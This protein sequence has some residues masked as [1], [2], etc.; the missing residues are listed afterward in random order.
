ME[1]IFQEENF[2]IKTLRTQEEMEAAFRLR[3]EVFCDEL[4]WVPSFPD[5]MERDDYDAFADP[6]GLFD[7]K[8][9]LIGH[10]RLIIAPKPFMIEKEFA[11]L[12][13]KDKPFRKHSNL[14]ESTRICIK[15]DCRKIT[16]GSFTVAHLLY[17]AIYQWCLL[18]DIRFFVTIIEKRYYRYLKMFF[19]F[20][21]LGKFLPLGDG[22]LSGIVLMDCRK[23][24]LEAQE[25]RP[26]FFRWMAT[27]S[28]P[29][30]S[31]LPRLEFY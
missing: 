4:K 9:E 23:F 6:I 25:K 12:L 13:S 11:C 17:K 7:E 29:D 15:K 18:H 14:A 24:E 5:G 2:L 8:N 27:V 26:D 22:V 20:E 28:T 19:P 1:L 10:V 30:P 3:H 21:S 31:R 16:V